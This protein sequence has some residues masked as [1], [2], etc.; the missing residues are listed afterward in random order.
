MRPMGNGARV[1]ERQTT[2]PEKK[3]GTA[4][5]AENSRKLMRVCREKAISMGIA[6]MTSNASGVEIAVARAARAR[7]RRIIEGEKKSGRNCTE[8]AP[9]VMP[10][11]A[12]EIETNAR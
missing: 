10:N 12:I 2:M 3:N 4:I 5:T 7:R 11:M 8:R 1:R 9:A 6:S